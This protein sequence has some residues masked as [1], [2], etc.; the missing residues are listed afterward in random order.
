MPRHSS[1]TPHHRASR[2]TTT[3]DNPFLEPSRSTWHVVAAVGIAVVLLL[4][5]ASALFLAR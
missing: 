2:P 4:G 5:V 3:W 1:V